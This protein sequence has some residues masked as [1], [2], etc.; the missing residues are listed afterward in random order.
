M[1]LTSCE[2]SGTTALP[3]DDRAPVVLAGVEDVSGGG[4]LKTGLKELVGVISAPGEGRPVCPEEP[5]R[6]EEER[7][8]GEIAGP[9]R[10]NWSKWGDIS[11][12]IQ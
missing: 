1:G 6:S 7:L 11:K 4:T 12:C 5:V 2:G 8:K 3:Q 9:H 10:Q